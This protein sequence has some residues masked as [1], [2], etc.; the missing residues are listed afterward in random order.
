MNRLRKKIL[1][2]YYVPLILLIAV[3]IV[4]AVLTSNAIDSGEELIKCSFK[5]KFSLY[6][7]GCGGSRSLVALLTLRPLRSFLLFPALLVTV[8]ILIDLYVRVT[9]SF[10]KNN[11]IYIKKFKLSLLIIIPVII[12]LNF[13]LRNILLIFGI[14]IIG[15]FF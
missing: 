13:F 14:D 2:F 15:D 7:P 4:Y 5:E 1:L 12:I 6:C 8:A 9:L 11:E 10:I 3:S